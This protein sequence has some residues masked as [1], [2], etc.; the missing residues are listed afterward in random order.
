MRC[1]Y[2]D[3]HDHTPHSAPTRGR[4]PTDQRARFLRVLADLAE[5]E[6][7]AGRREF[8]ESFPEAFGLLDADDS[9]RSGQPGLPAY[10]GAGPAGVGVRR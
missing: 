2:T 9:R 8:L 5:V 6:T 10:A 4:L 1:G 7:D 3:G